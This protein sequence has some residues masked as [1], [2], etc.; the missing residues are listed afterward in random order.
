MMQ[1]DDYTSK[2]DK[3]Q[4]ASVVQGWTYDTIQYDTIYYIDVRPK[5]DE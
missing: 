4:R 2:T 3:R 5:A 1:V